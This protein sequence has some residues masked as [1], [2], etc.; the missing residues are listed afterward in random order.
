MM[1]ILIAMAIVQVALILMATMKERCSKIVLVK[2][3]MIYM[4][5]NTLKI[6]ELI[7]K[8]T[9]TM[10]CMGQSQIERLSIMIFMGQSTAKKEERM[11]LAVVLKDIVQPK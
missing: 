9:T 6:K 5:I 10:T 7:T 1:M 8:Y 4:E 11:M 2:S 3:T